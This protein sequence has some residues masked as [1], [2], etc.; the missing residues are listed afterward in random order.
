VKITLNFLTLCIVSHHY[1]D[2]DPQGSERVLVYQERW[3]G[4]VH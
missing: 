2:F 4:W 1:G 3:V